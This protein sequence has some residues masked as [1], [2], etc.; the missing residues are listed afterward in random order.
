M[1]CRHRNVI[2][3]NG[4]FGRQWNSSASVLVTNVRT[5]APLIGSER[6][7]PSGLVRRK[8]LVMQSSRER[9]WA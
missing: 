8:S 7:P 4:S 5:L 3:V 1:N 6:H 2:G 9:F